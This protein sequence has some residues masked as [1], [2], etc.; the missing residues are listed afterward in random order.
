MPWRGGVGRIVL[1][2][3][4]L[5]YRGMTGFQLRVSKVANPAKISRQPLPCTKS[6]FSEGTLDILYRASPEY[7]LYIP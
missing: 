3:S 2:A 6:A 4:F 5:A 7:P 1:F